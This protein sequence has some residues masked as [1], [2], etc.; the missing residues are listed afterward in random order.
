MWQ[1][2]IFATK[3]ALKKEKEAIKHNLKMPIVT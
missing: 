1:T 3:L 2:N